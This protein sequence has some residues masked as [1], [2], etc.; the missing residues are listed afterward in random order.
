MKKTIKEIL[1]ITGICAF[2]VLL[3]IILDVWNIPSRIGIP[4]QHI[5]WDAFNLLLG[6]LVVIGLF[7][8]TY[9]A[10]DI[11]NIQKEHNQRKIAL[12][13]LRGIVSAC[14]SQIDFLKRPDIIQ[15]VLNKID[16]DKTSNED[17]YF[18]K[19]L[20]TP[21]VD[22]DSIVTFATEGVISEEEFSDYNAIRTYYRLLITTMI[23]YHDLEA[24]KIAAEKE[25]INAIKKAE[26]T[27]KKG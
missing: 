1:T 23:T 5:N 14:I 17:P 27:I 26:E 2:L 20:T 25:F 8:I 11:R 15:T 16:F 12:Y 24:L 21:F 10:L 19:L 7:F 3:F 6:N 18:H 13:M 9:R 4:I 22:H